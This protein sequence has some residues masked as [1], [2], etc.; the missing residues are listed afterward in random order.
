MAL[1]E[2]LLAPEARRQCPALPKSVLSP[3]AG[4][5]SLSNYR[6]ISRWIHYPPRLGNRCALGRRLSESP[7]RVR[8]TGREVQ[9][10]RGAVCTRRG[11]TVLFSAPLF[12]HSII[13]KARGGGVRW[14]GF[15]L[16]L[17]AELCSEEH[18]QPVS[19][20]FHKY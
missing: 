10:V 9:G 13:Y 11:V 3:R 19:Y 18:L 15:E 1:L 5:L 6:C 7:K 4:S 14:G 20:R 8:V 2:R 12:N 16:S 17:K